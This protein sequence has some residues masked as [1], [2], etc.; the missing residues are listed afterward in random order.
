MTATD[1]V[2][3]VLWALVLFV[4]WLL[5]RG[6]TACRRAN[7]A[8]WGART[9]NLLD[10]LNR[11]FCRDYH[12]LQHG[13]VVLPVSGPAIVACNHVSGLD[14]LLMVAACNRPLRFI[15]AKE[16]YERWWV[17]WLAR[18]MLCIPVDRSRNAEK[19]FYAARQ[20]L[21][22][23]EVV[24]IFPQGAIREADAPRQPLKRGVIMLAGLAGAPIIPM[25]LSGIKGAGLVFAALWMRSDARLETGP[26]LTVDGHGNGET[27]SR[28]ERFFDAE[29]TT[30]AVVHDD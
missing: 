20:A 10:G 12:R 5:Y 18:R 28:L 25:R 2:W 8:D 23:G 21:A 26:P 19:A 6:V 29:T 3:V 7:S 30:R 17:H 15:V 9:L 14:P 1:V 24:A 16:E 27:L 13:P 11:R 22:K 4:L